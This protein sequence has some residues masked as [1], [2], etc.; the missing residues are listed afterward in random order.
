MSVKIAV[1][2]Q[3]GDKTIRKPWRFNPS[4]ITTYRLSDVEEDILQLFPDVAKR[5]SRLTIHYKDS[6][7]GDVELESDRD[8]R[9]NKII[10]GSILSPILSSIFKFHFNRIIF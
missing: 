1:I 8:L 5:D 6:L 7:V 9:V 4:D 10:L 3:Q 2:L